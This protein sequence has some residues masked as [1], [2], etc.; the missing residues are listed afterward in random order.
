MK[1]IRR[2]EDRGHAN[3]GW[4]DSYHTFSFASYHDPAHMGFRALRVINDDTVLGGGGFDTHPHREMEIISYVLSGAL[5]HRD[6]MGTEAVMK[7]G[8]FQRISA[9]TGVFHSEY[10][11]SPIDPVH[12]LQIWIV[13]DRKGAKPDHTEKSFANAPHGV[14]NLVASKSGRNGS[15]AIN[16]DADLYLA[17]LA[18]GGVVAHPLGAGRHAWV[19]VAEG[20]AVVNGE[21]LKAGDALALTDEPEVRIEASKASQ[22]LLFDLN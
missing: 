8:D 5:K 7:A 21:R 3:H 13:P 16:Q 6:S 17:K 18:E 2:A 19:H 12:F 22:V 10:N 11:Y 15:I 4:L 14:L 9:G 20:E 1:S